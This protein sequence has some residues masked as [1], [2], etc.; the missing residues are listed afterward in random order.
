[1]QF[2]PHEPRKTREPAREIT[3]AWCATTFR[4]YPSKIK[5]HNY[6]SR[7]C[8]GQATSKK[9]NPDGYRDLSDYSAQ[10]ANMR[11]INQELNPTRM[12]D[13][14]R[15]KLRAAHLGKGEGKSYEKTH[16]RPTHR[17]IAEQKI[18]RQLRPGEVVH[19]ID[20][21]RRNNHPDNLEVMTQAEHINLHR[22]Q[23][24]LRRKNA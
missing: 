8:L 17:V 11:R 7:T 3:C 21:D 13:D 20:G 14:V 2:K 24:D 10:S 18:C 9:N 15:K 4:R 23:G 6:C 22:T 16:G 19:H 12:T 5:T 1:M